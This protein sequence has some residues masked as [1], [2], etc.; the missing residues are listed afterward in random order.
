MVNIKKSQDVIINI[1]TQKSLI[2]IY[3]MNIYLLD[4]FYS[5]MI[6]HVPLNSKNVAVLI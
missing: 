3:L 4:A 1:S 5:T 2:S 6:H